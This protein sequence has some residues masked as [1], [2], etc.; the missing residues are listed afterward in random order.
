[1]LVIIITTENSSDCCHKK[2]KRYGGKTAI[3][4]QL[5]TELLK[6]YESTENHQLSL[7]LVSGLQASNLV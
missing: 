1:M 2:L 7:Q 3:I 4:K 6:L 5:C